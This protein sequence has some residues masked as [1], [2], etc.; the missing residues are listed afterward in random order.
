[1]CIHRYSLSVLNGLLELLP[2]LLP[3]SPVC[4]D[5]SGRCEAR[6]SVSWLRTLHTAACA[7]ASTLLPIHFESGDVTLRQTALWEQSVARRK[8]QPIESY[9]STSSSQSN[10]CLC[11]RGGRFRWLVVGLAS[12]MPAGK[13]QRTP[14]C[15]Q[16]TL[17]ALWLQAWS[18]FKWQRWFP[19]KVGGAVIFARKWRRC[20]SHLWN[21]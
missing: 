1:M 3:V 13:L 7:E 12:D 8:R 4:S 10:R 6:C 18:P 17:R 19:P 2:P 5:W 11:V 9:A 16:A 21:I 14:L 15:G 20:Y